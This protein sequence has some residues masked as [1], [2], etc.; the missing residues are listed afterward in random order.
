M[1]YVKSANR[2]MEILQVVSNYPHGL[3]L[4]EICDQLNMPKSSTHEILHSM[5][6][7]K[8]LQLDGKKY[9]MGIKVFELGQ[10]V[11]RNLDLLH[12]IRP[13]LKWVSTQ[14]GMTA[15]FA[16]LDVTEIVYLSKIKNNNGI[17]VES[18]VGGRLPAHV[19]ALG[20][21]MLSLVSDEEIKQRFSQLVFK[22]YSKNSIASYDELRRRLIEIRENEYAEDIEE[23]TKGVYC[24]AVPVPGIR[25]ETLGAISLSMPETLRNQVDRPVMLGNLREAGKKIIEDIRYFYG[26]KS[27]T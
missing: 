16:I 5:A 14:S 19:T 20:K 8:F 2:V 27:L 3:T 24:L 17:T 12:A 15:Q 7:T 18:E 9:R 11:S 22:Q 10:T 13:H 21:A 23:F 4:S 26:S 1:T 25:T 6:Q